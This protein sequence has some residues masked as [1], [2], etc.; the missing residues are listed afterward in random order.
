[1][2]YKDVEAHCLALP[3]VTKE[4]PFGDSS[5]FKVGGKMFATIPMR[6]GKPQGVWFKAGA[7]SAAILTKI[8]GIRPCPYLARAHWVAM[9][10]LNP[11]TAKELRAYLSRAHGLVASGLSKKTR[12]ALGITV[13]PPADDFTASE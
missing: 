6:D 9:A 3:G 2:R 12:D 13:A 7:M 11:L 1:M 5:V 10:G 4:H 8:D